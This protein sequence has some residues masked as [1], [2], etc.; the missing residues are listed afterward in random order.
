MI[1]GREI[2]TGFVQFQR[3]AR[4]SSIQIEVIAK[5]GGDQPS[6]A[7]YT[8]YTRPSITLMRGSSHPPY[9]P[10]DTKL[11]STRPVV[12]SSKWAAGEYTGL[13]YRSSMMRPS[14]EVA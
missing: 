5:R 7:T 1:P 10:P 4:K 11:S 12:F 14:R 2:R 3:F 9:P 13:S 8:I 6:N